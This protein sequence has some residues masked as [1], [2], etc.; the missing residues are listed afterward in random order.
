MAKSIIVSYE[1]SNGE[2]YAIL[3]VGEK[4]SRMDVQIINAF[5]GKEATELWERLTTRDRKGEKKDES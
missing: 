3:V 5:Q 1:P 2:D 4:K